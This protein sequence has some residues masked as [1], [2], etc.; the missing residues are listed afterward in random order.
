METE[1]EKG[2]IAAL[3]KRRNA[4]KILIFL[5]SSEDVFYLQEIADNLNMNEMTAFGNLS[6]LIDAG[7]VKK[8]E[9]KVDARTKYYEIV[10]KKRAEKVIDKYKQRAA[11]RLAKLIP[12]NRVTAE[13]VK[14]DSRFIE[15]CQYH[16]L[17]VDEGIKAVSKCSKVGTEWHSNQLILWR[18]EQGYVPLKWA[19]E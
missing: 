9:N 1:F 5:N 12:Y 13:Q 14:A 15:T 8:M 4:M 17:T 11:F 16:G 18:K 19:K 2:T 10:D 7:V 3:V 6:K